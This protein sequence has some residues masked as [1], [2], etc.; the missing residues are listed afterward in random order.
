M[1]TL[2][3]GFL[4]AFVYGSAFAQ[5]TEAPVAFEVASIKPSPP[6]DGRGMRVGGTGGPGSKDPGRWTV[7]NM[8]LSN[9]VTMAY[10][11]KRYEYS[12]PSWLDAE[13]FDI[14]AKV[15][16]GAT[17]EQFRQMIQNML[18]ERFGLQVHREKKELQG[19]D[20]VVAKNGPKL[21]ESVPE[22]PQPEGTGRGTAS[23]PGPPGP[24]RLD[25]D[26]FPEL[27]PGR[28][29]MMI[30]MNG[31]ARSRQHEST[32]E[33]IAN[34]LANQLSKPVTDATGLKGKYDFTLT[35]STGN[36]MRAVPPPPGGGPESPLA[37]MPDTD[38]GPTIFGAV[39][40]QLGLKLES[41]KVTIELVVVDHIEKIPTEN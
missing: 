41:K 20:L 17:R 21:S 7:Q 27:P 13:R 28:G 31:R 32:S 22:P 3:G 38:S 14:T 10:N 36:G 39:Q 40:E 16:E 29:S 6:P 15:P 24:P 37:N 2:S 33:Q 26:G 8:S 11:L 12:G 5:T 4:I 25:K 23:M 35:W 30:M 18:R 19:Y 1:R 9:L 34:M